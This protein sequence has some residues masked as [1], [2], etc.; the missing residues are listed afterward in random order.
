MFGK[1]RSG[2]GNGLKHAELFS[3]LGEES[4]FWRAKDRGERRVK[5]VV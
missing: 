4:G 2:N 1:P 3:F 5:D